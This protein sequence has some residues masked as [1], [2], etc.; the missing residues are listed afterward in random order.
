M[1]ETPT[2]VPAD[3]PVRVTAA[4]PILSTPDLPRALGFYRDLLGAGVEYRFPPD[5]PSDAELGYVGLALGSGRLGL[6]LDAA[7]PADG[8]RQRFALWTYTE[9]CDAAVRRLRAA[10]VRVVEEPADQPW[11]ERIA[12]VIDPDGNE[13]IIGQAA[14]P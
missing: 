9:D 13:V 12:R 3:P 6:G 14:T 10:G 1:S 5:A 2:D 11:G 7:L 4:F 8:R